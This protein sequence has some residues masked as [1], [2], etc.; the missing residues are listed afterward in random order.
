MRWRHREKRSSPVADRQRLLLR[1]H[2]KP[3]FDVGDTA[4]ECGQTGDYCARARFQLSKP[5]LV[6]FGKC[7]ERLEQL[8]L[9]IADSFYKV[10]VHVL[11]L[12][13]KL[14]NVALRCR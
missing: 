13:T 2:I 3:L 8:S 12:S 10:V 11:H 4:F 5:L 6:G 14:V 7:I 1:R 9:A